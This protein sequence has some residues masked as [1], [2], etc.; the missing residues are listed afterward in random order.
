MP[1]F[2]DETHPV[3]KWREPSSYLPL[4]ALAFLGA[5]AIVRFTAGARAATIVWMIGLVHHRAAGR[6]AHDPERDAGPLRDGP[7]RHAGRS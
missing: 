6:V 3:R 5:G 1:A 2:G 7:R 4:L